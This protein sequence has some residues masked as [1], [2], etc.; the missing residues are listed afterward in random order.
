MTYKPDVF[1]T[2][3]YLHNFANAKIS[4][5]F[6]ATRDSKNHVQIQHGSGIA[7]E[8]QRDLD[9]SNNEDIKME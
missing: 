3:E 1:M 9:Q 8:L 5:A 4:P 2:R 6:D 7:I